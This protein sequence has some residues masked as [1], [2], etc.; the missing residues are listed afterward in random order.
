MSIVISVNISKTKGVPK[1]PLEKVIA[2]KNYGLFGDAHAFK[3][4]NRQVSFLDFDEIMAFNK[5]LPF[6]SFAENITVSGLRD[7]SVFVGSII[8]IGNTII[9][10]TQIGKTCHNACNIKKLLGSCIM[11]KEGIFG[12]ILKGGLIKP[13]MVVEA[14]NGK[15]VYNR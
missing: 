5:D 2:V 8:K 7:E 11:P 13:N 12:V 4:S 3:N 15:D 1:E 9:K 14:I 10:V 6:G